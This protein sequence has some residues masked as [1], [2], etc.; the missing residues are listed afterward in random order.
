M[1]RRK[2][3]RT[4]QSGFSLVELMVVVVI[5]TIILAVV[6]EGATKLTR[7]NVMETSKVDLTQESRQFVDQI[8]RDIHQIGYPNTRMAI[9]AQA[10]ANNASLA[11]MGLTGPVPATNTP[12]S[13]Q[14]E[15]DLDGSGT[16]QEVF[17]QL[18]PGPGNQCPCTLQRGTLPKATYLAAPATVPAYYTE[19][20]NVV[21]S[22]NTYPIA[23]NDPSGNAYDVLYAAYKTAPIFTLYDVTG[24]A[25]TNPANVRTIAIAVN[26]A[27]SNPD[28]QSTMVPIVSMSSIARLNN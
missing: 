12:L 14:F 5:L 22:G 24:T 16:V 15:G 2:D 6:I 25:T 4:R 8:M 17:V 26:V 10:T 13:I 28:Q 27:S 20:N 1:T 7:R 18:V 3:W 21:N 9:S 23:G 19:L 11:V